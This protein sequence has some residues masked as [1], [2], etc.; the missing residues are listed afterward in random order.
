M[1]ICLINPSHEESLDPILDPPLGLLYVA[2]VLK[3]AGYNVSVLDLS[4]Y[5]REEWS[6]VIPY[7]DVYGISIT[8]VSFGRAIFIRDIC[9][10]INS[11]CM[12]M[13]GGPHPTA[14][15]TEMLAE[16]DMVIVGEGENV[17]V[18]AINYEGDVGKIFYGNGEV[19]GEG[20]V[21]GDVN[22]IPF[23]DRD[24][25]VNSIT[26]YTRK[27]N[28]EKATSIIASRGCPYSCSYCINSTKVLFKN[29]R[30][31]SVENIIGELEELMFKYRFKG[32]VFYDDTFTIH[33]KIYEL[34]DEIKRLNIYFRC[35]GNTRRD[36]RKLFEKLYEAGCKEIS[37]GI[38]SGSQKILDNINKKVT[39][40]QN[41][42]AILDA[43][44]AGLMVKAFLMVGSPGESWDTVYETVKFMNE[45]KPQYWS[46]FNFVPLP[47]CDIYNNPDKYHIKIISRDYDNY[48]NLAG[49]N[50]S[51]S[52]VETEYM[53]VDEIMAARKYML[54]NLPRQVGL[55]Q[56]YY[57][58]LVT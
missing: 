28:G 17:I 25:L 18:D 46:L 40:E 44:D 14:L 58:K 35:N 31:R 33:P 3:M 43:K 42:I 4:F 11:S 5:N 6:K 54:K 10:K 21:G 47:G 20:K 12:I 51:G 23:P 13:V 39:V 57:K 2:T 38:E 16:F 32:F 50:E 30:F 37:F 56:D 34:L 52:V 41:R 53:D 36:N 9:K 1:R 22:D 19:N 55:L 48:F 45:T 8:T 49:Q 26:D 7:A 15:P 29:V 24:L 27:V